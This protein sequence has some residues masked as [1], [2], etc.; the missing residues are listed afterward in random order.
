MDKTGDG[1]GKKKGKVGRSVITMCNIYLQ[2]S[3]YRLY[4]SPIPAFV[5]SLAPG[6]GSGAKRSIDEFSSV[7]MPVYDPTNGGSN[8]RYPILLYLSTLLFHFLNTCCLIKAREN[9]AKPPNIRRRTTGSA[10]I[11]NTCNYPFANSDTSNT[12]YYVRI[13]SILF[14][15]FLHPF[16]IL[17]ASFSHPFRILFASFSQDISF[18]HF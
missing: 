14:A 4:I 15:S 17:F 2:T 18:L 16:R 10:D 6:F 1:K 7:A 13:V 3:L 9:F 12:Y 5:K 11:T 8:Y